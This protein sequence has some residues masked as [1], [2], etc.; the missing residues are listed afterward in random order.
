MIRRPILFASSFRGFRRSFSTSPLVSNH[1]LSWDQH[2]EAVWEVGR[3]H[4]ALIDKLNS[5]LATTNIEWKKDQKL[6]SNLERDVADLRKENAKIQGCFTVMTV[7]EIITDLYRNRL[8]NPMGKDVQ[9]ILDMIVKGR[10]DKHNLITYANAQNAAI[11]SISPSGTFKRKLVN[12]AASK[13]YHTLSQ[14]HHSAEDDPIVIREKDYTQAEA[15]AIFS[16]LHFS[17]TSNLHMKYL[18]TK[19]RLVHSI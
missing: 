18:D 15:I 12:S 11:R 19:G 5:R 4:A 14:H 2:M 13:I 7:L 17:T 3:S 1:L 10:F 8:P 16:F 9:T 6:I